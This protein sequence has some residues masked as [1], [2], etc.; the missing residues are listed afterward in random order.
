MTTPPKENR[1]T[2]PS[3]ESMSEAKAIRTLWLSQG[4]PAGLVRELDEAI[5]TA[6]DR[7]K[8]KA[9]SEGA[10]FTNPTKSRWSN[11]DN[12]YQSAPSDKEKA[13]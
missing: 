4:R 5:A 6:I 13:E 12:P 9:W 3:A 2:P 1:M 7:A 10:T 8:E 11:K